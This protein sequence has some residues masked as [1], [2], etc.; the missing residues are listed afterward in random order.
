M[1]PKMRLKMCIDLLMTVLLLMLMAYQVTGDALHEW[2]GAGMVILFLLHN[3]LNIQW[4]GH[5]F[6]GKYTLLRSLRTIVNF[7]LLAAMLCMAYSGIVL[8][9][10][11]FAFLPIERGMAL[12]RVMHLAGSYWSFVL[13]SIHLGLHWG[14]IM[15]MFR[16]ISGKSGKTRS[17]AL[18][19]IAIVIAGYGLV[20]CYQ[21]NIF[22]YMFRQVE[23]AFFDY[24]KSAVLVFAEHM[25]MMGFWVWIAYYA[26]KLLSMKTAKGK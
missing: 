15:G 6:R 11:V 25:A 12:A 22:A 26:A 14:M 23:F 13:M 18:R 4:Y 8:S 10:H 5:L 16:R 1:K 19:G 3:I 21:A 20:C 2:C 17:W 7:A 24:E 9:R